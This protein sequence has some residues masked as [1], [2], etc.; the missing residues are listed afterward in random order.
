SV[1]ERAIGRYGERP[2]PTAQGIG[3]HQ[4]GMIGRE[5]DA[6]WQENALVDDALVAPGVDEPDL[7][8]GGIAEIDFTPGVHGQVI[9]SDTFRDDRFR[10]VW[11]E[12]HDALSSV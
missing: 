10:P 8:V 9:G 4:E 3:H 6:V 7:F 11:C 1:R 12:R 2:H 5:A